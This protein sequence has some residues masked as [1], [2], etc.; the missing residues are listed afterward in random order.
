[1]DSITQIVLGAGVGELLL[2]RKLGNRAMVW[3]AVA[4]TI[5]DLDVLSNIWQTP[6]QALRS[7]RGLMHSA[8]LLTLLS[9]VMAW[10]TTKLYARGED[11]R[12]NIFYKS[13]GLLGR[14]ILFLGV[15][16]LVSGLVYAF[17]PSIVM[18]STVL[19]IIL[20]LAIAYMVR[21]F[22]GYNDP[23]ITFEAVSYKE[24]FWF[25][26][27]A[28]ITHPVLDCFTVYGTQL[29]SPFS[30]ARISWDNISVA[31]PIY[32]IL[33]GVPLWIASFYLRR[34]RTRFIL[35]V[36]GLS[37]SS[38]YMTWT[39]YNKSKVNKVV[40]NTIMQSKI[41]AIRYM[42]GPTILNNILW[43]ATIESKDSFYIGQY[44]L[45]DKDKSIK[46]VSVPKNQ[47][48]LKDISPDDFTVK[49]IKWFSKDYYSVLNRADGRL[50][51]NDL[52]YGS[53]RG[54]QTGEN[55]FIF[56]FILNKDQ[57][58][59]YQIDPKS[60]RP[61]EDMD[62]KEMMGKLIERIKGIKY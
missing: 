27:W 22:K 54:D 16:A 47:E 49:T 19:I 52:R 34:S 40:E 25:F 2:G 18:K 50:Q 10:I 42:N 58:G 57:E 43:S 55:D 3:G 30:D 6:S 44:S 1:L 24:W 14:S 59:K 21:M 46:L 51:I 41:M 35:A 7:H 26:F 61:A 31:D 62:T 38:A 45:L 13:L 60:Q 8:F 12:T 17:T 36:L 29:L 20:G 4:G 37:L 48:L 32:T 56:R 23:K 33:Y 5:P 28:M 53:Y 15:T 39:F 9:F 11:L